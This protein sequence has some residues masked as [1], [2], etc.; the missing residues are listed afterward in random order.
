MY[1]KDLQEEDFEIAVKV[2]PISIWLDAFSSINLM[3]EICE[4][5]YDLKFL[6]V[7]KA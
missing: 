7:I 3:G 1:I 2:K 5:T 6:K 4:K